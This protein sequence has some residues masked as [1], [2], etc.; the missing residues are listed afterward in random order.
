MKTKY[1][2]LLI[3]VPAVF[4]LDQL[5]KFATV[6]WIEFGQRLPA[7]PGFFDLVYFRNTGAAFG[8]LSG[9]DAGF[10]IP[11][12]YI[13]AVLAIFL[14]VLFF[15]SIREN[16][17]LMPIALS[18]VFGGIAGNIVDRIRLGYVVDFLSF[19]IGNAVL[20]FSAMGRH[21]HI[22][23]EWPAFNIADSAITVAM[24]LLAYSAIFRGRKE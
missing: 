7:I 2:L 4:V 10:R 3:I 21:F 24:V 18:L 11:F 15:R 13:V 23:L 17:K 5:T 1:R 8:L 22:D 19:H 9:T 6:R 20:D 12:F 14:L 16:E